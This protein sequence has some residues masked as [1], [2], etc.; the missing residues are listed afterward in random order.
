MRA[1]LHLAAEPYSPRDN[2]KSLIARAATVL[3]LTYRHAKRLWYCEE[4][5]RVRA[6]EVARLRAEKGRLLRLKLE[7]LEQEARELRTLIHYAEQ[8][9]AE[10]KARP[11]AGVAVGVARTA[12]QAASA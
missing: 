1:I 10:A 7:R 11:G 9:D 5:R 4:D 2:M 6:E 8:R 3:G 12:A